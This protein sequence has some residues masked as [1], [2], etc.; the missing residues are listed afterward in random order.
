M[1]FLSLLFCLTSMN[2]DVISIHSYDYNV[3]YFS[4]LN[5]FMKETNVK[6]DYKVTSLP[7]LNF[8]CERKHF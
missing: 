4:W 3:K 8:T 1:R 7:L 5:P 6:N 2:T